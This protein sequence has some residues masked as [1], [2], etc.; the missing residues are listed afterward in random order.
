M[1]S[2]TD[3][4]AAPVHVSHSLALVRSSPLLQTASFLVLSFNAGSKNELGSSQ[5][6]NMLTLTNPVKLSY[7]I[8]QDI[9]GY[10]LVRVPVDLWV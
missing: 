7:C 2:C 9:Q 6:V 10:L 1:Y 4:A 3:T 5:V 8:H